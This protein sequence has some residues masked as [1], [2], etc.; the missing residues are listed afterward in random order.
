VRRLAEILGVERS[1][2]AEGDAGAKLDVVC[3]CCDTTVVDLGLFR[4][5]VWITCRNAR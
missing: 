1:A 4:L 3:E 5:L 2:E